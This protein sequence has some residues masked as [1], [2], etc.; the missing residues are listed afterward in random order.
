M[1]VK[2]GKYEKKRKVKVK[3]H[4]YDIWNMDSTLALIIVPML[5][6]LRKDKHGAPVTDYEDAPERL[7][8]TT[9]ELSTLRDGDTDEKF[10]DRWDWIVDE[11]IFAF[12]SY[13]KD[14]EAK[15]HSGKTDIIWERIE[16]TEF[17]EMKKGP[18]DTSKFDKE[19]Y[20]AY[21]ERIE[22]GTRLFGKYYGNLWT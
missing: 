2:I 17:S 13:N 4:K 20:K 9:E 18:K 6:M 10:F 14:W 11:M 12:K 7:R 5:K 8:P 15:F 21:A 3:I 19:G 1:R 22:N 16:G